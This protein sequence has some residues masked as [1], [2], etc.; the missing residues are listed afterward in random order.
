MSIKISVVII[1]SQV[2]HFRNKMKTFSEIEK[3][4]TL[5][6]AL[7]IVTLPLVNANTVSF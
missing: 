3:A 1:K 6:I 5:S 7:F 2:T 4:F